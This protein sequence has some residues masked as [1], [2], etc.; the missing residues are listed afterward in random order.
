MPKMFQAE[1]YVKKYGKVL[2][3]EVPAETTDL[4][5][6]LCTDYRPSNSMIVESVSQLILYANWLIV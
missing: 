2:I 4:L 5:K 6:M 3:N 1:S